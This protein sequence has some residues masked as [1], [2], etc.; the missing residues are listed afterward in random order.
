MFVLGGEEYYK[1]CEG[2]LSESTSLR[3]HGL[4]HEFI[5]VIFT[6]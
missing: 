3:F 5:T 1:Y 2:W 6:R 4:F